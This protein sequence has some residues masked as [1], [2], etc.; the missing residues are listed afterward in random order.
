MLKKEGNG[1]ARR[2]EE[3]KTGGE[4]CVRGG[5]L[6]GWGQSD[7]ENLTDCCFNL[8]SVKFPP[9]HAQIGLVRTH[10]RFP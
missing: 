9:T 4:G 6:G 5:D 1:W 8:K 3:R 7:G 2:A 10:P